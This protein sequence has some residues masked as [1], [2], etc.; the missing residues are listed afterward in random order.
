MISRNFVEDDDDD[1]DGDGKAS[2]WW[3]WGLVSRTKKSAPELEPY[4]QRERAERNEKKRVEG[5]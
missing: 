1:D 5:K 2:L 3:W 4:I